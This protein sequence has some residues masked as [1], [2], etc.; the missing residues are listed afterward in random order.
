MQRERERWCTRTSERTHLICR[1][2]VLA[3]RLVRR[4]LLGRRL[5][6]QLLTVERR[7]LLRQLLE[8]ALVRV[9][10]SLFQRGLPRIAE[11]RLELALRP[12]ELAGSHHGL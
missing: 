2:I 10:S 6:R 4:L 3:S 9:P 5:L 7:L 8:P 11:V 1:N 12:L